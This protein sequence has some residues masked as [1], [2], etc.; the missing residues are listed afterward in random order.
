M[1]AAP[2]ECYDKSVAMD[3]QICHIVLGKLTRYIF[4]FL[5]LAGCFVAQE[6]LA[7]ATFFDLHGL[8]TIGT[9]SKT[10]T[11]DGISLTVSGFPTLVSTSTRFGIDGSGGADAP[12]LIDGG[13]GSAEVLG[14][15]FSN[16]STILDSILISEFGGDDAG[17]AVIK[18]QNGLLPLTNGVNLFNVLVSTSAQSIQWAGPNSPA[19]GR[20]FSVDGFNVHL[21]PEPSAG[22]LLGSLFAFVCIQCHQRRT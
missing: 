9:G 10:I 15:I 5:I 18:I 13:N 8:G 1:D 12:D 14:F 2:V 3:G 7:Q 21:V 20:G 19:D 11:V 4:G 17:N 6:K 22:F 16:N